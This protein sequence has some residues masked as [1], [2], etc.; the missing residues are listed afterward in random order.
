MGKIQLVYM[1][2]GNFFEIF[3][4]P[5][6]NQNIPEIGQIDRYLKYYEYT[7]NKT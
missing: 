7:K 2:V 5:E 3:G 4:I 6:N 1:N